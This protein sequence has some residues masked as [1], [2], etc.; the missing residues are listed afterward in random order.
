MLVE[1]GADINQ[2]MFCNYTAL[3]A[4]MESSSLHKFEIANYLLD[5]GADI[6]V[7]VEGTTTFKKSIVWALLSNNGSTTESATLKK[8]GYEFFVRCVGMGAR[9]DNTGYYGH[10]LL[11]ACE[12]GN[13]LPMIEYMVEMLSCDVNMQ[14]KGWTPLMVAAYG[15]G[16]NDEVEV[17][18]Y[19]LEQGADTTLTNENGET[20]YDLAVR[21][22]NTEIMAVLKPD[23]ENNNGA[24]TA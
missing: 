13:N 17:V 24:K 14:I 10:L 15:W 16:H 23:T 7:Y 9:L 19:L 20:A 3:Y 1:N 22:D 8:E 4:A 5:N 18:K 2:T 21:M 11:D 6:H 12:Y